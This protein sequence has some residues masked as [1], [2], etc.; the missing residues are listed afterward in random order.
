[1][2]ISATAGLPP[3]YAVIAPQLTTSATAARRNPIRKVQPMDDV[4]DSYALTP[5]SGVTDPGVAR[6]SPDLGILMH[7]IGGI[8]LER[9]TGK[10]VQPL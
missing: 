4:L 5:A 9:I 6:R 1:M 3:T 7:L 10:L 8:S 2:A